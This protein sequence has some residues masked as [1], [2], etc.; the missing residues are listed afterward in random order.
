MAV[1]ARMRRRLLPACLAEGACGVAKA[2]AEGVEAEVAETA[3][4]SRK[5]QVNDR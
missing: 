2:T 5:E 4:P 1:R 3:R